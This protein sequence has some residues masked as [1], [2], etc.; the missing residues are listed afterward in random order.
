MATSGEKQP[1]FRTER[2]Q[3]TMRPQYVFLVWPRGHTVR[4][5]RLRASLGDHSKAAGF[6]N[7]V[8]KA[9]LPAPKQVPIG[10]G[11]LCHLHH[12]WSKECAESFKAAALILSFPREEDMCSLP[13]AALL[14]CWFSLFVACCGV[15]ALV[16]L[17]WHGCI[18][19]YLVVLFGRSSCCSGSCVVLVLAVFFWVPFLLLYAPLSLLALK[20]LRAV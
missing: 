11:V 16:L 18:V 17:H 8:D 9:Q 3:H 10:K 20:L 12:E 19:A 4:A 13:K 5:L 15:W 6:G 1:T 2:A 7:A 14:G